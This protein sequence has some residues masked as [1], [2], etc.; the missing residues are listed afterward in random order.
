MP[1]KSVLTASMCPFCNEWED[2]LARMMREL[3]NSPS[4]FSSGSPIVSEKQLCKHVGRHLEQLSLFALPR[5]HEEDD[6][7]DRQ[8]GSDAL[9]ED[10]S[11]ADTDAASDDNLPERAMTTR[12]HLERLQNGLHRL[13]SLIDLGYQDPQ[14]LNIQVLKA[15]ISGLQNVMTEADKL[16]TKGS[17]PLES[18]QKELLLEA[19]DIQEQL[20]ELLKV[21][22]VEE[23]LGQTTSTI[24]GLAPLEETVT[25]VSE[26][27]ESR[28]QPARPTA[29]SYV[30]PADVSDKAGEL[31][32]KESDQAE[33]N[34]D[35]TQS[36][37]TPPNARWTKIN[38]SLVDPQA[39]AEG[40]EE[41]EEQDDHVIVWRVLTREEVQKYADR[42][43]TIRGTSPVLG[44]E[45]SALNEPERSLAAGAREQRSES[46]DKAG[47]EAA[48]ETDRGEKRLRGRIL[49]AESKRYEKARTDREERESFSPELEPAQTLEEQDEDRG[50]ESVE[51]A[52]RRQIARVAGESEED[53][54]T[55]LRDTR[56]RWAARAERAEQETRAGLKMD[57]ERL[58]RK[59]R[60]GDKEA[61][62]EPRMNS[63]AGEKEEEEQRV[64]FD[65]VVKEAEE[66]EKE[67]QRKL[68]RMQ[69]IWKLPDAAEAGERQTRPEEAEG[70]SAEARRELVDR[71]IDIE[72]RTSALS[73][74]PETG[75]NYEEGSSAS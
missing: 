63:G 55:R 54:L 53:Y 5:R 74:E 4:R 12:G 58:S 75:P 10:S 15:Q 31:K 71:C 50:E 29:A 33:E 43:A 56:A 69:P 44:S 48:L 52:K 20:S 39:L 38:R 59:A 21:P 25:L 28:M 34:A 51:A 19:Q 41:F 64:S 26:N 42:T 32:S 23:V 8:R 18:F 6:D 62:N 73:T 3:P 16:E 40:A 46:P 9:S 13:Q 24:E 47:H 67:N 27:K 65:G 11:H 66:E 17:E 45:L 60:V 30:E 70:K 57:A 7:Q 68:E 2:D 61:L 1:F 36:T 35:P 49:E 14:I 72:R 37:D 22:E